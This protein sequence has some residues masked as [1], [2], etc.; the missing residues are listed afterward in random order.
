MS[1]Y[2]TRIDE[3]VF[4]KC[5]TCKE[6]KSTRYINHTIEHD[7]IFCMKCR[8][9]AAKQMY[10]GARSRAAKADTPFDLDLYD[11]F[12]PTKCP[13][14]GIHLYKDGPKDNAPSLDRID[15][16]KGYIKG[17]VHVISM[18]A[19]RIKNDS[20]VEELIK[21]IYNLANKKILHEDE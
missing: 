15:N 19:N 7:E 3:K 21:L 12:I 1:S 11:C 20:T 17:N 4:R 18:R 16:T 14:L 9:K 5:I 6:L 10:N 13:I 2:Y 8:I